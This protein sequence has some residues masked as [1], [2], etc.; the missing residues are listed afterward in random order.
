MPNNNAGTLYG[1]A[2]EFKDAD[3]LMN[4]ARQMRAAGYQE[5]RAYTPYWVNGLTEVLGQ[6]S[7][8]FVPY[9][10]IGGLFLGALTGF[11]LQYYTSVVSYPV[12]VGGRPLNS[13]PSFMLVTFELAILFAGG[14][15]VLGFFLQTNLP[16][17]YHPV[18]NARR[19]ELAS[20]DRFFLCVEV[21]DPAFNIQNT[22]A[23]LQS[24][25]S[26]NVSEVP[27]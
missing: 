3:E 11:L 9:L 15:T 13:W 25:G 17:P 7:F 1:L 6:R 21:T 16:L 10:A 4:A 8:N 12:N 24:L 14:A 18:F 2:A 19:F 22:R 23:L 20:K 27:S 26:L 5:L